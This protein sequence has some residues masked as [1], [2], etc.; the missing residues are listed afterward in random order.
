MTGLG[1]IFGALVAWVFVA[2]VMALMVIG[3]I[4]A[5]DER[6]RIRRRRARSSGGLRRGERRV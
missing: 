2:L 5:T 1:V 4:V 6:A 3:I